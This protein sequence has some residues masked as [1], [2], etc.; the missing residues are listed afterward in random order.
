VQGAGIEA[1]YTVL[2]D[3]A[4]IAELTRAIDRYV[5]HLHSSTLFGRFADKITQLD[6]KNSSRTQKMQEVIGNLK[7]LA[8]ALYAEAEES[9]F[10]P[11]E[12]RTVIL[13]NFVALTERLLKDEQKMTEE[14]VCEFGDKL[15]KDLDGK[16]PMSATTKGVICCIMFALAGFAIGAA[17][18]A[19]MTPPGLNGFG[20]LAGAIFGAIKGLAAAGTATGCG[21]PTV[22]GAVFGITGA[23]FS[24]IPACF[25][26][27]S[28][29]ICKEQRLEKRRALRENGLQQSGDTVKDSLTELAKEGNFSPALLKITP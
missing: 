13:T 6:T 27:R 8:E 4:H 23:G 17:L 18:G 10:K 26:G 15:D 22:L 5:I 3:E 20:A 24:I 11:N 14:E 21:A 16:P 19:A 12:S 28:E 1:T 2:A 9:N 29:R 25:F 7:N